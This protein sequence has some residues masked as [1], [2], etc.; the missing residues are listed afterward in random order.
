MKG[1][2]TYSVLA[3]F[4]SVF[5]VKLYYAGGLGLG[6]LY[7]HREV[8]GGLEE[9]TEML[10]PV[11]VSSMDGPREELG[12]R[13][14]FYWASD[15]DA[16]T[17]SL[18]VLFPFS[19]YRSKRGEVSFHALFH[20]VGYKES[21][22]AGEHEERELTLF[23]LL[24][25]RSS[26]A[27][28]RGYFALFPIY[29]SMNGKFFRDEI[30]F[31][32]FPLYL[33][34]TKGA[35]TTT[36][37]LW[38]V[39][40][41]HSGE[42]QKG[43]RV[44]PL[45]GY[46]KQEQQEV[47]FALWPVFVQSS[48]VFY[49]EEIESSSVFP[50]YSTVRSERGHHTTYLWPFINHTLDKE[51]GYE[52]WD[53]PWPLANYTRQLDDRSREE[54]GYKHQRRLFP[55][56]SRDVSGRDSDGFFLWPLYRYNVRYMADH[57]RRRTS[58][59]LFIYQDT[60]E[61]AR[62]PGARDT[63]RVH[64]WPLL[65]YERDTDGHRNISVISPLGPFLMHNKGVERNYEPLWTIFSWKKTPEGYHRSS[66]LWNT[67]VTE[68]DGSRLKVRLRP[69]VPLFS[70]KKSERGTKVSFL[71]GLLGYSRKDGEDGVRKRRLK[72][73][74]IPFTISTGTVEAG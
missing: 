2:L 15:G 63:R 58:F 43:F 25:T 28:E 62:Y 40:A 70:L 1:P 29:G 49:G 65:T 9:R 41:V 6:P 12:F 52:R 37:Y 51:R 57:T 56:Y 68:S 27:P 46:R 18:D 11:I 8:P 13:P 48:R 55:L 42:G 4:L 69:I 5:C 67:F 45:F 31:F 20:I 26:S 7:E 38:P 71:G 30:E 66:F 47:K 60:R 39:F 74:Y 53:V 44:W 72:L 23:P 64:L 10:G 32:L 54:E 24:F 50:L 34:T 16:D 3:V 21:L 59:L 73:L 36:S 19:S 35:Q 17:Q 22:Y 33:K 14:L 61:T